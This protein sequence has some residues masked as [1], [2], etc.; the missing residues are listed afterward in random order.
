MRIRVTLKRV[1]AALACL[2]IGF[3]G[4]VIAAGLYLSAPA[5]ATIGPPPPGVAA[6]EI[7]STSGSRLHGWWLPAEPA[8][9]SVILMHGVRSNRL[10]MLPRAQVLHERGFS[11]LL[12]DFQ[13]HGESP[14][15]RITFG[16]LEA[17][18]AAAA[19]HF[20]RA[21]RPTDRIGAI[22][23]S[24]GG[25]ATLLG[26]EPL[27]VD[28][29]VLESVYPDIDAALTNRLRLRLG[30]AL[31]AVLTPTFEVLLPPLIGVSPRELRPIDR[32]ATVK[33]PLL[34]A[35]GSVD[36]STPLLE[37]RDLFDRASEP[38][39]FWAVAGAGHVDLE[40][41]DPAQYWAVVMPFLARYVKGG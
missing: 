29:L 2:V 12:F 31:P 25:A 15:N 20:V 35:S 8:G 1:F 3:F 26:S 27:E 30:R 18:D 38:R 39:Q 28:A 34:I 40:R 32:I 24:L 6:V 17:L 36:L 9:R 33:A 7:P 19:V 23:V 4:A 13:A 41:F 5:P 21:Q 16:K 14:G 22:G 37:A 11:V 10:Q